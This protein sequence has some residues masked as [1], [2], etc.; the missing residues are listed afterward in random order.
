MNT[1]RPAIGRIG[2]PLVPL[3][4]KPVAAEPNVPEGIEKVDVEWFAKKIT[5]ERLAE[6]DEACLLLLREEARLCM[7]IFRLQQVARSKP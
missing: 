4:G 6:A 3:D 2:V 1:K 5:V 7:R